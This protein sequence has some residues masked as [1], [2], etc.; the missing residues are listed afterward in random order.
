MAAATHRHTERCQ[1]V[2]LRVIYTF[3][4]VCEWR[5]GVSVGAWLRVFVCVF[6]ERLTVADEGGAKEMQYVVQ[7]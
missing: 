6:A 4:P 2:R 5:C 1:C 3:S 7:A